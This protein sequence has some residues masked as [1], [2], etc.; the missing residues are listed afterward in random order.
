MLLFYEK[1]Y[2]HASGRFEDLSPDL[3]PPRDAKHCF[4]QT[5]ARNS[6]GERRKKPQ[7]FEKPEETRSDEKV[8]FDMVKWM[9]EEFRVGSA[10]YLT[11]G[12]F[13]FEYSSTKRTSKAVKYQVLDENLY[14]E[15]YRNRNGS[16][17]DST[18]DTPDPFD[19]GCITSIFSTSNSKLLASINLSIRVKKLYRPEN[20]HEGEPLKYRSDLNKLYWSE[21][22]NTIFSYII[23]NISKHRLTMDNFTECELKFTNIVG[24]CYIAYSENLDKSVEEWS[25]L[26]PHRFYFSE[27]YDSKAEKFISPSPQACSIG[28][29]VE[30]GDKTKLKSKKVKAIPA[31]VP[32]SFPE[33]SKK[34]RTLDVLAGCGGNY[35]YHIYSRHAIPVYLSDVHCINDFQN[36]QFVFRFFRGS[37]VIRCRRE[38]LGY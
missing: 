34:L 7:L 5:C 28:K 15:F 9:G 10:V 25:L 13:D 22:G 32:V 30:K 23:L 18:C 36:L 35:T 6:L 21:E 8:E 14:T 16:A 1:R 17:K 31:N 27:A 11:P 4:C 20:T 3:E 2:D 37:Q 38:S 26:G 29:T 33:I 12:T 19:V 24:K